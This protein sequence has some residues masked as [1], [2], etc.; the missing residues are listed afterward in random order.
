MLT[1]CKIFDTKHLNNAIY[2]L[3]CVTYLILNIWMLS[4]AYRVQDVWYSTSEC[5]V[6]LTVCTLFDAQHLNAI[7]CLPCVRHLIPNIWM[8]SIAEC[9]QDIWYPTSE[10][11]H[12]MYHHSNK[13][14]GN[15]PLHAA[16]VDSYI[17]DTT[18]YPRKGNFQ[19]L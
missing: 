8:L 16:V 7:Y 12:T 18:L 4:I 17:E 19:Q 2:C 3:P 6:L 11:Y 14:G 1:A 5:H 13:Y 10:G 15:Q 9:V